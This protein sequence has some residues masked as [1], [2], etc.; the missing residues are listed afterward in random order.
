MRGQAYET[1]GDFDAALRD[2]EAVLSK[3]PNR[4]RAVYGA[5]HAA[6]LIGDRDN[7]ARARKH[8]QLLVK[9]SARADRPERRELA[10]ARR[11]LN[12][13]PPTRR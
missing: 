9:I 8:F 10:E 4:F 12:S 1:V 11:T 6:A 5:G 13:T 3:E 2:Y 7:L